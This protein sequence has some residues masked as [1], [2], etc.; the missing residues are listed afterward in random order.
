MA[1]KQRK[2]REK[3]IFRASV[4]QA[5]Y[6]LIVK[7]GLEGLSLRKLAED[8][9]YSTSKLYHEFESK[10]DIIHLLA[11]DICQRQN[12]RLR[13]LKKGTDA[14]EY[15]LRFTHEAVVFYVEEPASA[16]I[17]AAMRFDRLG[18]E[19][20]AAFKL[21]A[22]NFHNSVVALHIP[23]LSNKEAL[24]EG[25]NVTRALML[26]AL[27]LLH[28]DSQESEKNLVVKIVDDGMKLIIAGWKSQ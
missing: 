8:I 24:E 4:I 28:R 2:L 7:N 12:E 26:G 13:S 10:Q 23:R 18:I 11:E 15:L 5:A 25:L 20:P 19:K 22:E 16:S 1:I 27:S 21:A 6:A 3:E 17:L 14:E 9:E